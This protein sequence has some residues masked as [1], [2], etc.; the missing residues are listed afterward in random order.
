M[1]VKDTIQM[2]E[3]QAF[4]ALATEL[5][6]KACIRQGGHSFMNAPEYHRSKLKAI[7]GLAIKLV[8][9]QSFSI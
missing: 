1:A 5:S 3:I 2:R 8:G 7:R 4:I 6:V 9:F